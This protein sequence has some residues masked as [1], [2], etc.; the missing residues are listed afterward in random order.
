MIE[1]H[2]TF[3]ILYDHGRYEFFIMHTSELSFENAL[4][5]SSCKNVNMK[6]LLI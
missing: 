2:N 3:C 1:N 6:E 4:T 5:P